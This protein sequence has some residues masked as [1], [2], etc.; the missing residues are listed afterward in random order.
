MSGTKT[1]ATEFAPSISMSTFLADSEAPIVVL[2]AK[3]HFEQLP[4]DSLKK[5]AHHL[6]RA[7]HWGTRAV[8]RSVSPE[9][10]PI[11]DLILG[12]H[13]ALGLPNSNDEYVHKLLTVVSKEAVTHYLEYA[14][15]FLSNL[16]NYKSFGDKKF[17]PKILAQDFAKI[18]AAGNS[19]LADLYSSIEGALYNTTV[20]L[21]GWPEEGHLSAYYPDSRN[22]LKSD[23]ELINAALAERS[24]MPENTRVV[25]K[26][27]NE[28]VVLVASAKTENTTSYYPDNI[29][30]STGASV[31]IKFGDHAKEFAHIV[32]EMTE[33]GKYAANDT[34]KKMIEFYAESFATGSMN[35]HKDS[36]IQ[37]VKDLGPSV[38]S[39]IGF[40]ETYRDPSGVRG[41]WEGLVAMVNQDRTAKFGVLVENALRL[42]QYLPWDKLLE[43]DKFTP[44]DFTS[45]E[46]LTF[47][48]SGV[49]AGINIPNYDDVRLNVGF[50]NV[51]LGN[52]LSANP[53]NPKKE[54]VITFINKALQDKFRK[55]RDDAFEV[56]VGLHEL[57]G[58][59]TGKLLQET[60]PGV[61]NFDKEAHPEIKTYFAPNETWGSLFGAT[62]G[63]FEECRAELVALFLILSKP[64]EVL[65]IFNIDDAES[66]KDVQL[67][68]T[69][70]MARAGL[71]GLEFWDPQSMKW[72]QPHM[73]ARFG[74][75]KCLNKAGVASLKTSRDD[76]EDLEIEIDE[77]KLNTHAV[78]ALSDF[79]NNLHTFKTTANAKEGIAFYNDITE[80]TPD[81]AKFRDTVLSKKL[82]R[83]QLIQANTFLKADGSVEVREYEESEVGMI[84]S[85]ADRAV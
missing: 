78:D 75:F 81:Y 49:P 83:K 43:K 65:P 47:A 37:W 39:N 85:F 13:E 80:V 84:Q 4:T 20:G 23:I 16:G 79:L 66:Q 67:I 36:Q 62:A 33:A 35:A 1:P 76:F 73:Q 71:I 55:W 19:K 82:P 53:K 46:V 30:L 24:I 42:I 57:L 52:V 22:I 3:T 17:V 58:H 77:S 59:G 54:E 61:F 45:L 29:A 70:L 48:G 18:A 44:P 14:S 11:Y 69:L 10:E 5:Y 68:A 2:S 7:S 12:L 32:E 34:Q 50:K 8:L 27:S 60:S 56:Q 64:K 9:S 38:E 41:E 15:Q 25:K 21:L 31:L 6:S 72:G 28:F 26:S 40:I 74:I 51:S 63:S